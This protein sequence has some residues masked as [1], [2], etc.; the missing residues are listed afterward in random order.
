[1]KIRVTRNAKYLITGILLNE[2]D[3]DEA[4]NPQVVPSPQKQRFTGFMEK[5][6][7]KNYR[8]NTNILKMVE[9][10]DTAGKN[11]CIF[12]E[13]DF[14]LGGD[15]TP[16]KH[17]L[18]GLHH[19]HCSPNKD[20]V[21]FRG[22]DFSSPVV[23]PPSSLIGSQTGIS[24]VIGH[25]DNPN[26]IP[27]LDNLLESECVFSFLEDNSVYN[28]KPGELKKAKDQIK[29]SIMVDPYLFGQLQAGCGS[30]LDSIEPKSLLDYLFCEEP[31]E[32]GEI[33]TL[34]GFLWATAKG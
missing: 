25:K 12:L 4:T 30:N 2:S 27:G 19:L 21:G 6:L 24:Q 22:Y 33:S 23:L 3:P 28:L 32:E 13:E 15:I 14:E 10:I 20:L 29:C 7:G 8:Y 9:E 34:V 11:L 17:K 18:V 5:D 26:S 16:D 31:F 1:V